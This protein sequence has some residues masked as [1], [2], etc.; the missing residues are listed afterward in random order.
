MS[1]ITPLHV[2]VRLSSPL[3]SRNTGIRRL[4]YRTTLAL[5]DAGADINAVAKVSI[6]IAT[7][8]TISQNDIMPLN[9]AQDLESTSDKDAIVK[10]LLERSIS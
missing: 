5:L 2:S 4:L 6:H 10:L 7:R 3:L 1:W 9:V 8:V